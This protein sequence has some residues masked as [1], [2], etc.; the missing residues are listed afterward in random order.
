M[1]RLGRAPIVNP[2]EMANFGRLSFSEGHSRL[3]WHGRQIRIFFALSV[4]INSDLGE[5]NMHFRVTSLL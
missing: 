5:K 1:E 2:L 4:D 3:L